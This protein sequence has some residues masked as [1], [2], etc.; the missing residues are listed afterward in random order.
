MGTHNSAWLRLKSSPSGLFVSGPALQLDVT[1][2][3]NSTIGSIGP[4]GS[5]ASIEWAELDN[6]PAGVSVLYLSGYME[7]DYDG[8]NPVATMNMAAFPTGQQSYA[9]RE[10]LISE[11]RNVNV[12]GETFATKGNGYVPLDANKTFGFFW[13]VFDATV[14]DIFIELM[15]YQV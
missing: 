2:I 15:G 5:G 4:T 13:E 11:L 6:L 3:P 10:A 12:T 14:S 8:V 1:P 9:I 7:V